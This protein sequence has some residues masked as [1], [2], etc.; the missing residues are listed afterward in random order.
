MNLRF[1]ALPAALTAVL[2]LSGCANDN[3]RYRADVYGPGSLNQAQA[4]KT[5]EILSVQTARIA[6]PNETKNSAAQLAGTVAGAAAGMILGNQFGHGP[7]SRQDARIFGGIAGGILGNRASN[8]AA[9]ETDYQQGVQI[10]FRDGN[11]MFTSV[12]VG[13]PCEYQLGTAVMIQE[14][15]R[16]S[17]IQPNNP[18]GCG[19]ATTSVAH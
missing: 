14:T 15:A 19:S 8:L 12:Q 16:G 17:R 3:A 9:G 11:Q 10:T 6:L 18:G 5:V 2:A 1:L 7:G 4:V 13:N